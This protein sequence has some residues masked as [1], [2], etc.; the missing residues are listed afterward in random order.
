MAAG[1]PSSEDKLTAR[2]IST[3]MLL[4]AKALGIVE[5]TE[6]ESEI[7]GSSQFSEMRDRMVASLHS[8][9]FSECTGH[10]KAT[11]R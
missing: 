3:D 7:L 11:S 1:H 2:K 5:F 10:P 8:R 9:I 6:N 4:L